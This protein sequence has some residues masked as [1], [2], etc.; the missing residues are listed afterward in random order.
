M[1]KKIIVAASVAAL[2]LTAAGCGQQTGPA[3][4]VGTVAGAVGGALIGSAF[5][6]GAGKVAA[7]AA[8]TVIGG[9]LGNRIGNNIDQESQR[10]A[11]YA[12]STA[13]ASGS[14]YDWSTSSARGYVEPGPVYT[15]SRGTCRRYTHTIYVNGT[16]QAGQGTACR[17][18]DG[19]WQIVS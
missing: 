12:Q 2:A 4:G 6:G 5:G 17:N 15:D 7:I 19:T 13:V 14:R 18:P 8:G 16:P 10:Q 9:F 11:Y 3:E 1:A